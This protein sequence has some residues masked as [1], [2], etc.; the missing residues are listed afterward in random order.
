MNDNSSSIFHFPFARECSRKLAQISKQNP[1]IHSTPVY[2]LCITFVLDKFSAY[3]LY[4]HAE[5]LHSR[6]QSTLGL[7]QF[8]LRGTAHQ[9]IIPAFCVV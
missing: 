4:Y 6:K 5:T 8:W 1:H 3:T 2:R 9:Q 7:T